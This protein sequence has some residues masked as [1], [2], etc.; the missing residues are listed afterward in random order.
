MPCS[1]QMY[2][3]CKITETDGDDDDEEEEEEEEEGANDAV[4]EH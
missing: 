2:E 3:Y 1:A 4:H